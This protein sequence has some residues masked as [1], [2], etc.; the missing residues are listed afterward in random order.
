MV[1]KFDEYINEHMDDDD[2]QD[3][4]AQSEEEMLSN[5]FDAM[6]ELQ[7]HG[8]SL[9]DLETHIHGFIEDLKNPEKE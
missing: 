1:K 5:L 9:E 2:V 3:E 4:E 8:M 7:E 6:Y